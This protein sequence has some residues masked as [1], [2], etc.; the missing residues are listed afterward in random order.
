MVS[1]L[2]LLL[3]FLSCETLTFTNYVPYFLSPPGG[4][5][6]FKT[7]LKRLAMRSGFKYLLIRQRPLV[8]SENKN[9]GLTNF[10]PRGSSATS[11][12]IIPIVN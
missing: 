6:D 11:L 4:S 12:L 2:I 5:I 9:S 7:A 3:Y 8:S 1:H 10:I